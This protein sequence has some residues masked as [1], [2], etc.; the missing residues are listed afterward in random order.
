VGGLFGLIGL[1]IIISGIRKMLKAMKA[2]AE[3]THYNAKIVSHEPDYSIKVNGRPAIALVVRF[4]DTQGRLRQEII[5]TG[6]TDWSK[7]PAGGSIEIAEYEGEVF[8]IGKKAEMVTLPGQ[9]ELMDPFAEVV[10]LTGMSSNS[11]MTA[12]STVLPNAIGANGMAGQAAAM[13]MGMAGA[14]S[15]ACPNCGTV[16]MVMPGTTIVCKCGRQFK[17]TED[18]MIV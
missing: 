6:T 12:T 13:P 15:V 4:K 11:M 8:V 1:A 9:D 18:H 7:F 10:S 14:M 5:K 17:L 16:S 3:G 2:K